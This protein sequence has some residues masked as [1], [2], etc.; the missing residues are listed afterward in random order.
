MIT[1]KESALTLLR[2]IFD[3]AVRASQ[4]A[5]CLPSAL[6]KLGLEGTRGRIVVVGCGK[7]STGMAAAFSAWAETHLPARLRETLSGVLVTRHGEVPA[8]IPQNQLILL[9]AAH[10]VPDRASVEA[11]RQIVTAVGGLT[12]DDTVVCLITGGGSALMSLPPDGVSLEQKQAVTGALLASG[13]TIREMNAVR[14]HLS[15]IKGGRLAVAAAP[16]RVITLLISDV[17][18]DDPETIASGPTVPDPSTL[19]EARAVTARYGIDLPE[20]VAAHFQNIAAESP[21]PG[22]ARFD[23]HELHLIATPAMA[24]QAAAREAETDGLRTLILG[25]ALEGE[26]REV[27]IVHAG[28]ARSAQRHGVPI[29]SPSLI[30][31]GGETTVTVTGDG[32]GQGGRN[33][34]FA[35]SLAIALDGQPG[36]YA[37]AADTDGIDGSGGHAGAFV[38][39]ETL[40]QMRARGFDPAASLVANNSRPL[41]EA[42]GDL[43][44]TGPTGTNVNDLRAMLILPAGQAGS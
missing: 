6:E 28:I 25:D 1:D 12:A 34:E 14:K 2:R 18:G 42:T 8:E 11:A 26:A 23:G 13:A 33:T 24:L 30:L 38:T 36:I 27:G 16:A 10:P 44:I 20:A 21:K 15:A 31:S 39:P 5:H 37:I 43:L 22:D 4:P 32:K 35:L 7:A 9:E 17:P 40:T 3:A 41:F 19:E 29:A